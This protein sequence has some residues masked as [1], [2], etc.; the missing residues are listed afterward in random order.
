MKQNNGKHLVAHVRCHDELRIYVINIR[1]DISKSFIRFPY[2]DPNIQK[3]LTRGF[4]DRL[5][6]ETY[7]SIESTDLDILLSAITDGICTIAGKLLC[8]YYV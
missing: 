7:F 6:G 8:Y 1:K 2:I 5:D 4:I 3:K